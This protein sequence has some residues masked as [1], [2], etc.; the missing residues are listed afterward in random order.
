MTFATHFL[1]LLS[2]ESIQA[3]VVYD[4]PIPAGMDR[5]QMCKEL[6]AR[7]SA[8]AEKHRPGKAVN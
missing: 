4:Q 5:K 7:V 2:K 1:N 3:K 6:H 8:L